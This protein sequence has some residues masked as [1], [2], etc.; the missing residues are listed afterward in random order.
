VG[1]TP[2][3]LESDITT[4]QEFAGGNQGGELG[5]ELGGAPAPGAAPG[6][7]PAAGAAPTV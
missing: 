4:G 3:D 6:Q 7:Q 1:V 2:G 5:A